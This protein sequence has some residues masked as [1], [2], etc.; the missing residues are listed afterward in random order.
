[1]SEKLRNKR[2]AAI[3]KR[4]DQHQLLFNF[5]KDHPELHEYTNLQPMNIGVG[6]EFEELGYIRA[7]WD[8]GKG[9]PVL[10]LERYIHDWE[11]DGDK[12]VAAEDISG[13]SKEDLAKLLG[14]EIKVDLS[15]PPF[16]EEGDDE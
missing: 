5:V 14:E 7:L 9:R 11:A 2:L 3:Q 6:L 16:W 10:R 4:I 15:K 8:K 12:R 1:M 13:I